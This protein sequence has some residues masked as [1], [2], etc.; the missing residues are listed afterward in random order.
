MT[1]YIEVDDIEG[2]LD[3]AVAAGAEVIVPVT[4]IPGAVTM[5]LFADPA[6]AVVGIVD[7]E[8]PPVE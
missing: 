2:Y 7:S 1:F 6:G 5:A 8:T 3:R 4:S